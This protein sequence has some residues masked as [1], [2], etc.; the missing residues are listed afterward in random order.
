MF[1]FYIDYDWKLLLQDI[2]LIDLFYLTCCDMWIKIEKL[3]IESKNTLM[4]SFVGMIEKLFDVHQ[5]GFDEFEQM[6]LKLKMWLIE[7][8]C[9]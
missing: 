9:I 4:N 5:L 2:I 6:I 7:M 1:Q 3:I 8:M